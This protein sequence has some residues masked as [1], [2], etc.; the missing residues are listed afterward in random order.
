MRDE[1]PGRGRPATSI[2][3]SRV[4]AQSAAPRIAR[5]TRGHLAPRRGPACRF[6]AA[7]TA[8]SHTSETPWST[9]PPCA[10][11]SCRPSGSARRRR[12]WKRCVALA[13]HCSPGCSPRCPPA[14][15][16]PSAAAR[17]DATQRRR[18]APARRPVRHELASSRGE[19]GAR[20]NRPARRDARVARRGL[21]SSPAHAG[22]PG[23]HD[24][25]SLPWC[26]SG[27]PR[28]WLRLLPA[29]SIRG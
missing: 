2:G 14:T 13:L 23:G 3:K 20:T 4:G 29:A 11:R 26:C 12:T 16:R 17:K 21:R 5:K 25:P 28:S 8:P 9:C 15:A 18:V 22:H 6:E 27:L 24:P 10:N 1:T 19:R 7:G